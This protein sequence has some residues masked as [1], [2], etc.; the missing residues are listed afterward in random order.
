MNRLLHIKPMPALPLRLTLALLAGAFGQEIRA[1]ETNPK[2]YWPQWR[3]PLATGAAPLADPPQRWSETENVRWKVTLPGFGTSTPIVWSNLV[4]VLT[5]LPTGKP[6]AAE[7]APATSATA[8]PPSEP[9]RGGG[10]GI[11]PPREFYRFV[12]LAYDRDTGALR[13]ARTVRETVPHEGHHRDHGF[14]SASPVTDGTHLLAYFGSRGLHCLTLDGE[15]KWSRDFGQMRTRSSF[16]EGASPALHGHT[17]VVVWDDESDRDF[18]AALDV[19]TGRELWRTARDEPTGWSTPLIVEFG[20]QLQVVVN[21]SGRVRGYA[22]DT[23]RELWTCAGQ[24]ANVIPSPVADADTVYVTSGF[25]GAAL[26]AIALGHRGELTDTAAVRWRH[27]RN[28]PYVPSPLLVD[29]LLYVFREN[30]GVLSCFDARSG[31]AHFEAQRVDGLG[32]V[33]ASPVA[34]SGRVYLLGRDGTCVVLKHGPT[35]EI[36]AKNKVDDRTDASI[37]LAGRELFL[38]GH[39]H[40]CCIAAPGS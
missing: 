1:T 18:I 15:L 8:T 20:G 24:T 11:N 38:R 34:A 35:L 26:Y 13:W 9:R 21:G 6:A 30:T 16:G 36:L 27:L 14:A 33:Y 31:R 7:G 3:G 2:S 39:R 32:G 29:G 17:V 4:F 12:V 10:W 22:L 28:T 19:R 25:R 23:G 37:A 5:A 40:L